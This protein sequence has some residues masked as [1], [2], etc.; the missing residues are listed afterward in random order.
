MLRLTLTVLTILLGAGSCTS[1]QTRR[2]LRMGPPPD[3]ISAAPGAESTAATSICY[4]KSEAVSAQ[5]KICTYDCA[6]AAAVTTTVKAVELCL[7]TMGR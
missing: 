7:M 1:E 4:L 6:G 5:E 2:V 3:T